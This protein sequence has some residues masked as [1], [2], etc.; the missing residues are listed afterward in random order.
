MNHV[1]R[2]KLNNKMITLKYVL[3]CELLYVEY[4]TKIS[5]LSVSR[6][7]VYDS[8]ILVIRSVEWAGGR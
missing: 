6:E 5:N 2:I 1:F 8:Q 4:G 7:V 3:N